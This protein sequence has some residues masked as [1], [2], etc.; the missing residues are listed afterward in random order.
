MPHLVYLT[1]GAAGMFCG[2]CMHDN[3]LAKAI[4]AAGHWDVTLVPTYTPIRT[5]EEN[6]SVDQVFFGGINVY[7]QQKMPFLRWLPDFMD[8]WLDRPALIRR[9]TAKASDTSP[10]LLGQLAVSMLKGRNGNQRKEVIRLIKWLKQEAKP[11]AI[12]LTNVLIGGCVK[13]LQRELRVPVLATLQ[14]DD[15]FLDTLPPPYAKQATELAGQVANDCDGLLVHSENYATYMSKYLNVPRSKMHLMR[16]GIDIDPWRNFSTKANLDRPLVLGYLARLAPEKGVHRLIDAYLGLKK[17]TEFRDLQLRVAGWL[18][19]HRRD[20]FL[21]HWNKIAAA[22]F[23]SDAQYETDVD[24]AGKLQF[25]SEIDLLCVPTQHVEPKG[26]FVLEALAAGVPVVV[27]A[28]GAF[29]ELLASTNGGRL[30]LPDPS[31]PA[32]ITAHLEVSPAPTNLEQTLRELLLDRDQLRE[33]GQKGQ[34]GVFTKHSAACMAH[35][36]TELLNR[37]L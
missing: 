1:A 9:L 26:L 31:T 3:A 21:S 14:G 22:G 32:T 28:I 4:Q 20:W 11:D 37:F 7:L 8:R 5:D 35:E 34:T 10:K 36:T 15:A 18:G 33:L 27:P 24:R 6:V 12:I 13:D 29:P 16:L 19:E 30:C 17:Q 2:S 23:A 25:L